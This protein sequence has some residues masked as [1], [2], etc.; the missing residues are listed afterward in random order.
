MGTI[1]WVPRLPQ[2]RY[3]G[4]R[5]AIVA[6][7]SCSF[8]R[9]ATIER[10]QIRSSYVRKGWRMVSP[11]LDAVTS[12]VAQSMIEFDRAM[13]RWLR[14]KFSNRSLRQCPI[15][16]ASMIAR[17][18]LSPSSPRA[19]GAPLSGFSGLDRSARSSKLL[20]MP[21]CPPDNGVHSFADN[22]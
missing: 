12:T 5:R 3:P 9:A 14:Q 16:A 21:R 2:Y 10:S 22:V 8:Q 11:E 17:S 13:F 20:P 1:W 19:F 4:R 15:S 7:R 18:A 6:N